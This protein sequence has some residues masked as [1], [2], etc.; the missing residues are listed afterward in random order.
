M[1]FV[2][3]RKEIKKKL[4]AGIHLITVVLRGSPRR[5]HQKDA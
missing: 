4:V 1:D 5:G 2:T 3:S